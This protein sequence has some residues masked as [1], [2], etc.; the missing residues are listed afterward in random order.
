M[1]NFSLILILSV[2]VFGGLISCGK[3][4]KTASAN[5]LIRCDDIGMCH[6]VN[7][8]AKKLIDREIPFSASVMV[9]CPWFPEAVK[10]L[11][12]SENVAVG[13]HLTLNSEWANYKWGPVLGKEEVPTLVN[14]KGYFYA[15]TR[16]FLENKPKMKEVKKELEA[17]ILKALNSGLKVDYIDYHM[18]T[19]ISTPEMV[20][21]VEDLAAEYN[22]GLSR[23]FDERI[24]NAVYSVAPKAKTDSLC[25]R[26]ERLEPD[27]NYLII[28]HIGDTTPEMN[29]LE[30]ENPQGLKQ[31]SLHRKAETDAL[32]SRQLAE[33]LNNHN[34]KLI[35]YRDLI[36]EKGLK[37]MTAPDNFDF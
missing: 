5:L 8:M 21:I 29:A 10:I 3:E 35:T 2:L 23:W 28:C 26:I 6:T 32:L 9:C 27:N 17:Q 31:I 34:I 15:T 12:A 13:I 20:E 14:D 25:A 30:D 18:L 22:L 4:K 16:E 37:K 33:T 19:A 36:N 24:I 7:M 1:K 11:D